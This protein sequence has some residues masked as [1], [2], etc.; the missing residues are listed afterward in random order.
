MSPVWL[1]VGGTRYMRV[2]MTPYKHSDCSPINSK[3]QFIFIKT[4]YKRAYLTL[5]RD[6]EYSREYCIYGACFFPILIW[7]K[8]YKPERTIE[9]EKIEENK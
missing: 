3:T 9:L 8:V 6:E 7:C 5:T 4:G 1:D 2:G